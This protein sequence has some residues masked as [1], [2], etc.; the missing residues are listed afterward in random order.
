MPSCCAADHRCS[1][2]VQ[3]TALLSA[4]CVHTA[5]TAYFLLLLQRPVHFSPPHQEV[6]TIGI[7]EESFW[8]VWNKTSY[9]TA[10]PT[11]ETLKNVFGLNVE[12]VIVFDI[13]SPSLCPF[14]F[15]R[16]KQ[17]NCFFPIFKIF[18]PN[19]I[20]KL[21]ERLDAGE[22]P[23]DIKLLLAREITMLY[24]GQEQAGIYIVFL[25]EK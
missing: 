15:S 20:K 22:N 18:S 24:H 12:V 17:I 5:H 21:K 2:I 25:T 19:E 13:F 4:L 23:R 7:A 8:S 1:Q 3:S 14:Y 16:S 6:L 10:V 11:I 9:G